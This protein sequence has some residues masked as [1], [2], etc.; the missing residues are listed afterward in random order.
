MTI[1]LPF[2]LQ[3]IGGTSTFARKFQSGMEAVGHRVV[4]EYTPDYDVLFLIVQCPFKYL[5]DAKRRG[6]K[7]VQRLDGTYYWTVSGW[8]FPLMNFKAAY[9][10]HLF[11]DVTIY[12]SKY[13]QE[14]A[15]RFLGPKVHDRHTIIYNGVDLNHF[16]PEGKMKKLAKRT[17]EVIFFT[18]SAFRRKDQIEPILEA[19][20]VYRTKYSPHFRCV[21]AGTFKGPVADVPE[22]YKDRTYL[23]FVGKVSNDELPHYERA[24]AAFLSTHLNPPCP[25]NIIESLACG[26]P[27]CGVDDGAMSELVTTQ[28]GRLIAAGTT[29]FWRRRVLDLNQFAA[30]MDSI[31][32]NNSPMRR[33]ARHMAAQRLGLTM[34]IESYVH[35][36]ESLIK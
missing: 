36:F 10:R 34:M 20:E 29:G 6:K 32:K 13:S 5:I 15:N 35:V 31:V 28:T 17:H 11:T 1:F 24:A 23:S 9:I 22:H 26:L 16:S 25:N 2:K 8:K 7:I 27:V 21:I 4:F 14:C 3:D 18:A 30:N 19:L 12:Q 33:A